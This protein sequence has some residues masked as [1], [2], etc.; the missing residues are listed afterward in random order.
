VVLV[1]VITV[2]TVVANMNDVQPGHLAAVIAAV[3]TLTPLVA[4]RRDNP[5]LGANRTDPTGL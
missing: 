1:V 5:G 4:A 3:A 2:V